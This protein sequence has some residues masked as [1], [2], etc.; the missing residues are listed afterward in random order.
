MNDEEAKKRV[1][2][3]KLDIADTADELD[4]EISFDDA[5]DISL[6]A[7][8]KQNEGWMANKS[9]VRVLN[10]ARM[11][12]K[13][14]PKRSI[15]HSIPLVCKADE[16]PF[17]ETCPLFEHG[18]APYKERCPIEIAAIEDLFDRYCKELGIDPEDPENTID[19]M[20]VKEVVDTD[21]LLLR[22]DN[23]LAVDADFVVENVV[24]ADR[25]G[26]PISQKSLHTASS[27]KE[28]LRASKF[29]TLQLLNSTRRDKNDDSGK[30]QTEAER[31]AEMMAVMAAATGQIDEERK[32]R[33]AFLG[34]GTAG[35]I[36]APEE[37]VEGEYVDGEYVEMEESD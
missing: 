5:L 1:H 8:V 33:E 34:T 4:M 32:R 20:M 29:K 23:K 12:R 36:E 37:T 11:I 14:S 3:I 13:Q 6:K 15:L 24:G 25:E 18:L 10:A 31:V 17:R 27:Y 22:C 28:T 30:K 9:N 7:M 21:I 26:N 16:C 19:T 2:E 35:E